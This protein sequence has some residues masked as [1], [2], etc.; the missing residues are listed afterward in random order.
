[1]KFFVASTTNTYVTNRKV[2][3]TEIECVYPFLNY[4]LQ[5]FNAGC[6]ASLLSVFDTLQFS[7]CTLVVYSVFRLLNFKNLYT[8]NVSVDWLSGCSFLWPLSI[9]VAGTLLLLIFLDI[10][11]CLHSNLL[12]DTQVENS[13]YYFFRSC[14]SHK[15]LLWNGVFE[16]DV[17]QSPRIHC[18]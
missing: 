13:L 17:G 5:F 14:K 18:M 4:S 7:N 15:Q 8:M 10:S 2:I 1:M 6:K 9:S 16:G 12:P 11:C 3:E